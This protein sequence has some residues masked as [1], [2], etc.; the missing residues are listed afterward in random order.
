MT[1]IGTRSPDA[2]VLQGSSGRV[3]LPAET[4][5]LLAGHDGDEALDALVRDARLPLADAAPMLADDGSDT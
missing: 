5:I 1:P 3:F 4:S 2:V